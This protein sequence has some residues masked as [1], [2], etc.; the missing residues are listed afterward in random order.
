M[1]TIQ[2]NLPKKELPCV[3]IGLDDAKRLREKVVGMKRAALNIEMNAKTFAENADG[4]IRLLDV[5]IEPKI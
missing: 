1:A 3:T 5:L 4:L 2:E